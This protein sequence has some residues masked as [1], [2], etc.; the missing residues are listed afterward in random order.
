MLIAK[1]RTSHAGWL[2]KQY[3][4]IETKFVPREEILE[5]VPK[6]NLSAED[7]L[8]LLSEKSTNITEEAIQ[9]ATHPNPLY[10]YNRLETYSTKEASHNTLFCIL[11]GLKDGETEIIAFDTEGYILNEQGKT[12][13]KII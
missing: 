2:Y 5:S 6:N 3:D 7:L 10:F 12:I 1:I 13:E 9:E 8:K 11:W 4:S